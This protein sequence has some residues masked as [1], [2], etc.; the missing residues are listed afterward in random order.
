MTDSGNRKESGT[1]PSPLFGARERNILFAESTIRASS[2]IDLQC[3][4]IQSRQLPRHFTGALLM[5]LMSLFGTS[6]LNTRNPRALRINGPA[7]VTCAS[8]SATASMLR[9]VPPDSI[10]TAIHRDG[11]GATP[12]EATVTAP[13][14]VV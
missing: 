13:D 10:N 7:T 3:A 11:R 12:A 14:T 4:L 6:S 2:S 1:R 5:P 8:V 9:D